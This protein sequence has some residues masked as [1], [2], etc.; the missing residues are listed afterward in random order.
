MITTTATSALS[1]GTLAKGTPETP[2][3]HDRAETPETAVVEDHR[4]SETAEFS[5]C[6]SVIASMGHW[7]S[8]VGAGVEQGRE[9]GLF[10]RIQP[11][12]V[13]LIISNGRV[14]T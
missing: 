11:R 14:Y 13:L 8:A 6:W 3:M 12:H 4:D 2:E 9:C 7:C 10:G 5:R 1:R